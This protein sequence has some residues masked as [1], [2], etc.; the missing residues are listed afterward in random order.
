MTIQLSRIRVH[1][2]ELPFKA[3]FVTSHDCMTKKQCLILT[4]TDQSGISVYSECV[5]QPNDGYLPETMDDARQAIQREI[6]PVIL[7][8]SLPNCASV[9][10]Y[11][12]Q[13][14]SSLMAIASIEMACWAIQAEQEGVSLATRL[15]AT[16]SHIDSGIVIGC[17]S[18]IQA[19]VDCVSRALNASYKK[20]KLKIKPDM[21]IGVVHAVRQAFG[22]IPLM[23]DAN[24]AYSE[25]SQV[26]RALDTYGLMMI[27]QPLITHD[28]NTYKT[29]QAALN[30]PL[31][32]DESVASLQD[33]EQIIRL[34]AVKAIN[35]KPG[36]VGGFAPAI[37][38]QEACL[39]HAIRSWVGGMLETG[40]GRAYNIAFSARSGWA[41]PADIS[42]SRRYVDRDFVMPEISLH[43]GQIQVPTGVGIGVQVDESFLNACTL[44]TYDHCSG[45]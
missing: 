41:I 37:K 39:K 20:I 5:A 33:V 11:L 10:A 26:L 43:C 27:E 44:A 4:V 17:Q 3:S 24:G 25:F 45:Q 31:C 21:D 7:G 23:V 35:I 9:F 6:A 30:T 16:A 22:D 14:S 34:R 19:T 8:K 1:V 18:S 12:R 2:V 42:P 13:F 40:I 36:R 38:I 32:L 28:L 15:G 29:V